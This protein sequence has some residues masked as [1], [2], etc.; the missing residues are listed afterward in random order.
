MTAA[1]GDYEDERRTAVLRIQNAARNSTEWFETIDRYLDFP[2]QQFAYSLL[3]RSQ[4]VSHENLRVRDAQW[5]G[6]VERWFWNHAAG[7][8]GAANQDAPSQPIFAPVRIG[9]MML[10]NRIVMAPMLTYMADAQG[11]TGAFHFVHYGARALGGTGLIMSEL[12]AVAGGRAGDPGV[13]GAL[14]R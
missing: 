4:R 13:S 12:L 9:A 2:P 10:P 3:T 5:L 6:D 8:S 14:Q 1:L 7:A 11:R